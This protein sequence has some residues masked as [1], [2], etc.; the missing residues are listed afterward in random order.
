MSECPYLEHAVVAPTLRT[1][2]ESLWTK[3][4]SGFRQQR[5]PA[6]TRR[7]PTAPEPLPFLSKRL[8]LNSPTAPEDPPIMKRISLA[9]AAISAVV[10]ALLT[11]PA[12]NAA[13]VSATFTKVSDWGTGFEGKVTVTND[14]T[15][16]L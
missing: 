6:T 2:S 12:A 1:P 11:A 4:L 5:E 13:G 16:S 10:V 9:I 8:Y 14:T 15:S 3:A 7:R